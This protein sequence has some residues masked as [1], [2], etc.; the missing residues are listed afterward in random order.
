[1][2]T[3]TESS[4][5]EFSTRAIH[6]G[7]VPDPHTGSVVPPLYQ[8]STFAKTSWDADEE[9]GYSRLANPTRRVT[10]QKIAS[11]E[12]AK[13]ALCFSS[14]MS[15]IDAVVRLLAPGDEILT[16]LDLYGGTYRV[17]EEMYPRWGIRTRYVNTS[18]ASI[19]AR[20][21][22]KKLK[23]LWVETPSNP[24]LNV[25]DISLLSRYARETN[26]LFVVDNTFASPYLQNPLEGGADIVM[27][28]VTKY[29]SGHSD[30]LMGALA[31]NDDD[32][33]Q[34][35][36]KIYAYHGSVPGPMDCFL[37]SRGIKTL[38]VR[39]ERHVENA[40]MVANMLDQ[41][42]KVERVYYPGLPH[43]PH[44]EIAKKQMRDF[45]GILSFTIKKGGYE[46]VKKILAKLN[47]F[48]LAVS[49]GGVES[50]VCHP[51][52]MTHAAYS[53]EDRR[54]AGISENLIRLSVGIEDIQ[55]ILQDIEGALS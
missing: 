55:D 44:H 13:Y 31:L 52:S 8:T 7:E 48:T 50:L 29:L 30:L 54:K 3:N 17:F 12:G 47:Y 51:A 39:M 6:A 43:H 20:E 10:E 11:L 26:T 2:K 49:L 36:S 1:M 24:L 34:R 22:T 9:Y 14:G 15:A 28:S 21:M 4:G 53:E 19:V 40:R 33:H 5:E 38:S 27:H 16:S 35:L 46:G 32:L 25:S 42:P 18:D 45:G 37:A 41:H 23:L